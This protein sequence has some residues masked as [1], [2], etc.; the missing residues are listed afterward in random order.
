MYKCSSGSPEKNTTH[1]GV[2]RLNYFHTLNYTEE[3]QDGGHDTL[4]SAELRQETM[5]MCKQ[6]SCYH[7]S[8][9]II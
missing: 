5:A 2:P 3:I 1:D 9:V 8:S 6:T 4:T 7:G